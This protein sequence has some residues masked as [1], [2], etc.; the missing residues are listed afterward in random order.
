MGLIDD[1]RYIPANL[2][3]FQ[4]ATR[5]SSIRLMCIPF[6]SPFQ[7][8]EEVTW[9]F[10]FFCQKKHAFPSLFMQLS[11][12]SAL[13]LFAWLCSLVHCQEKSTITAFFL[14]AIRYY[15]TFTEN[16]DMSH[17][18]ILP[19]V[20]LPIVSPI[21]CHV[22]QPLLFPLTF[23]QLLLQS[24]QEKALSLGPLMTQKLTIHPAVPNSTRV[25]DLVL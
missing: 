8:R 7:L 15:V 14:F 9:H 16:E 25:Q 10:F 22:F 21:F 20:S 5:L 12:I 1:A 4:I 24:N 23:F 6:S 3:S 2:K 13:A 17:A 11:D 19:P 18:R